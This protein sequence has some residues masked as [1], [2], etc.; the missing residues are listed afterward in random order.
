ME[1]EKKKAA[2]KIKTKH[3]TQTQSTKT[4]Y[5]SGDVVTIQPSNLLS[6]TLQVIE[7]LGFSEHLEKVIEISPNPLVGAPI[8]KGWPTRMTLKALFV[9]H[10]DIFGIARRYFFELASFFATS[11]F[12]KEKLFEFS[13]TE[14]QES[15][16]SYNQRMRRTLFEV[17]KDFPS[18]KIPLEYIC[19][20]I[21][22]I[23]P[24][25]FSI[26]SSLKVSFFFSFFFLLF[27][28]FSF[29]L[30]SFSLF[31]FFLFFF[32]LFFPFSSFL[33]NSLFIKMHPNRIRITVA[34]INYK[35]K[36]STP[37][38]GVCTKWLSTLSH[39]DLVPIWIS[40][41]TMKFPKETHIPIVMIG[42]GLFASF[43]LLFSFL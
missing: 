38:T 37:R 35:T 8:P 17:L 19:D 34:V 18:I 2:I 26:S 9:K 5:E 39:G 4:R 15:L 28:F 11:D 14:G 24:R 20:L 22:P 13:T 16:Y 21:Q 29:S 33:S 32:F 30:F 10:L 27:F 41:G 42:P 31:L 25:H 36:M 1:K 12:E 7:Y 23:Q 43:P 6:E 40:K 3:K